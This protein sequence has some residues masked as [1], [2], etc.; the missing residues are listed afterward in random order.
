MWLSVYQ[1]LMCSFGKKQLKHTNYPM[2]TSQCAPSA[3]PSTHYSCHVSVLGSHY[4]FCL[5]SL[6]PPHLP[7]QTAFVQGPAAV[8]ALCE[9][10]QI[11]QSGSTIPFPFSQ[12]T[13]LDPLLET[14]CVCICRP[15]SFLSYTGASLILFFRQH[16]D[17][18]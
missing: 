4:P 15:L 10:P 6:S 16:P 12:K 9:S 13:A 7:M 11:S 8:L 5:K 3:S 17:N 14:S 2:N 18:T 1:K